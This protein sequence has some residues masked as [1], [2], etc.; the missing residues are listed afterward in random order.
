MI[1]ILLLLFNRYR[2]DRRKVRNKSVGE[3]QR[4]RHRVKREWKVSGSRLATLAIVLSLLSRE[5][6]GRSERTAGFWPEKG[7]RNRYIGEKKGLNQPE[8]TCSGRMCLLCFELATP[9]KRRSSVSVCHR[10]ADRA[11]RVKQINSWLQEE[12][13]ETKREKRGGGGGRGRRKRWTLLVMIA[14]TE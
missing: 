6:W 10:D 8:Y 13:H 14:N 11:R 2:V 7:S 4:L 1:T 12:R 9:P 3:R 5:P